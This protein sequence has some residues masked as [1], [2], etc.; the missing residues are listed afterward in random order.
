MSNVLGT[1]LG[2]FLPGFIFDEDVSEKDFKNLMTYYLIIVL[3]I[4]VSFCLPTVILM[5][6]KP[7]IPSR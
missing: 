5:R 4:N 1:V 3:G 2:Y 7:P 6:T